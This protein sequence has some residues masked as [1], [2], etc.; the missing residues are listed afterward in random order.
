[1]T[2]LYVCITLIS[3]LVMAIVGLQIG[4]K[5]GKTFGYMKC[6]LEMIAKNDKLIKKQQ[7]AIDKIK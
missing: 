3:M 2:I 4:W 5:N 6:Q 1:M 7:K